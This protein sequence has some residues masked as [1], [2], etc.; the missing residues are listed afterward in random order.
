MKF[1]FW[2]QALCFQLIWLLTVVGGNTWLIFPISILIIHLYLSPTSKE[3]LKILP[4]A[5]IGIFLDLSFAQLGLFVFDSFPWWLIILWLGFVLN[6]GH[7]L[8]FLRKLKVY[9]Q[10][11][12]GAAGGC[13]AYLL[14]WKLNAVDLPMGAMISGTIIA[15][16]WAGILPVMIRC[17]S[18]LRSRS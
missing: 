17:D 4:L 14:S 8:I 10:S 12:L 15:V 11:I 7:S 18:F 13:Y 3:D 2:T 5:L 6:F 16:A 9:W 1:W